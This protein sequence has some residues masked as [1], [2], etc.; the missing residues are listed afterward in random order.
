MSFFLHLYLTDVPALNQNWLS[1]AIYGITINWWPDRFYNISNTRLNSSALSHHISS[2]IVASEGNRDLEI[3]AAISN[4]IAPPNPPHARK[5]AQAP[6]QTAAPP[7]RPSRCRKKQKVATDKLHEDYFRKIKGRRGKLELMTEM[8]V[9]V[10]LEIFSHVQP[11]D[12][13]HLSRATKA[14][15]VII[16][17]T[18]GKLFWKQVRLDLWIPLL[19]DYHLFLI[20]QAYE[21]I[22]INKPPPCPED[23]DPTLYT[24]LLFGRNCQ[25]CLVYGAFVESLI[26]I[27]IR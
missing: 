4:F 26:F 15:R 9:D 13:L 1:C 24:S 10:L 18:N 25:L 7:P 2:P 20:Y 14:L 3:K 16:T 22:A 17:G 8:P 23:V 12:L 19:S 27:F 21:N 5:N 6:V 11:I